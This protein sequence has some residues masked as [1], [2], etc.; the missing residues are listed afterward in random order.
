MAK[1]SAMI[2]G[3]RRGQLSAAEAQFFREADPWGFILFGR[4]IECPDQLRRLTGSLRE[5]VGRAAPILIDQEG[6][7]VARMGAPH[8]TEWDNALPFVETLPKKARVKAMRLRYHAIAQELRACGI[9]VNCAPMADLAGPNTHPQIRHRCYSTDP[10]EV[11]A[12]GRAVAEGLCA[13]GVM[14]VLKHAPGHGRTPLDSHVDLPVVSADRDSLEATDFV[15]FA[16]LADLPFVMTSHIVFSALDPDWPV[17]LSAAAI[18]YLRGTLGIDGLMM[19]DDIA[20]GALKMPL[21]QRVTGALAAGCDVVLH[22]NGDAAEMELVAAHT[23]ELA[24]VA[25]DRAQAALNQRDRMT[26]DE[27]SIPNIL[28]QLRTLQTEV[29]HAR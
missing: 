7:R 4:N 15:P 3:C 19:T 26:P 2:F 6:G 25:A 10:V 23:P 11:A 24:G 20:M 28:E 18:R 1:P 8:W 12:L 9:D 16:A 21:E 5:S 22:C 13:G 29:N 27:V 14:P 17:T